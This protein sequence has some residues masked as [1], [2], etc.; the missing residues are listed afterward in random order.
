MSMQ[1]WAGSGLLAGTF[2]QVPIVPDSAH[3]LQALAQA[4]A[5][6][7]PCAQLFD[8]HSE[9]SE[10]KAPFGFFPHELLTQTFPFEQFASAVQL[11]KHLLPLHAKGT[12]AIAS[13]ATQ[14]PLA[15]QVAS[16][17]YLLFSQC[18]AAQT[19][20]IFQRRQPPAPSHL[21]S[22]PQVE[23]ACV[24]H[25]FRMS[26][27]PLATGVHVPSADCRAQ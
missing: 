4:V 6:Q 8:T 17:V 12:H 23:A 7:T 19:V 26:A 3:D 21:P 11:P 24:W 1:V 14:L 20:P 22:V 10:Q 5:Q 16:G 2:V 9:R 18:S 13:G 25:M 15:L 27:S